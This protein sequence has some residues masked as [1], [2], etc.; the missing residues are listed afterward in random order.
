[1]Q[2]SARVQKAGL[3]FCSSPADVEAL[4]GPQVFQ[5]TLTRHSCFKQ[6]AEPKTLQKA[7]LGRKHCGSLGLCRKQSCRH[8]RGTFRTRGSTM[9]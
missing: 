4:L 2:L 7:A 8:N 3:G 1:M 9:S 5:P 6:V